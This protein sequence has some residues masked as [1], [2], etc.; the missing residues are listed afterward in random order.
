MQDEDRAV[1]QAECERQAARRAATEVGARRLTE[2]VWRAQLADMDA[3][4]VVTFV[5][6]RGAGRF[7][8]CEHCQA[9]WDAEMAR[10]VEHLGEAGFMARLRATAPIEVRVGVWPPMGDGDE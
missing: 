5:Q 1:V 6:E 10:D 4:F 3:G 9:V 7:C 2:G 8:G